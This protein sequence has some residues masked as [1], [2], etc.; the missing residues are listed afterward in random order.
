MNNA[1]ND[2][3]R[4]KTIL[5]QFKVIRTTYNSYD[6]KDFSLPSS[7]LRS[8]A[9]SIIFNLSCV[10]PYAEI[11]AYKYKNI[12]T[13]SVQTNYVYMSVGNGITPFTIGEIDNDSTAVPLCSVGSTDV[14]DFTRQG[15]YISKQYINSNSLSADQLNSL[16][17]YGYYDGS[18]TNAQSIVVVVT[19][20]SLPDTTI[21]IINKTLE[22]Y[23]PA[24]IHYMLC[25]SIEGL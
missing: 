8:K 7:T 9:D 12:V 11:K 14:V 3:I 1:K 15:H 23:L 17:D 22:K 21:N 2:I 19:P 6:L 5:S 25:D 20:D 24:N 4:Y 16:A 18:P 10:Q 13:P